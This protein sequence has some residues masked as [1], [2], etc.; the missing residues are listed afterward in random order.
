MFLDNHHTNEKEFIAQVKRQVS[1]YNSSF[2]I[3]NWFYIFVRTN[4]LQS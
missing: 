3:Y 1:T 2:G 4:N